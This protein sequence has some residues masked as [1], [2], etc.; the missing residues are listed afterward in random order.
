MAKEKRP[1]LILLDL[2]MPQI[3]GLQVLTT[4]KG[5]PSTASI[6]VVVVS[7]RSGWQVI[8]HAYKLGATD[9]V[10]KPFEYDELLSRVR[11]VLVMSGL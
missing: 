5:D 6:P 7:A 3:S 11:R 10:A 2:M 1:D 9:F 4:L 8:E